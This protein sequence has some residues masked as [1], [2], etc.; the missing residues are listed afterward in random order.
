MIEYLLQL[1]FTGALLVSL[2]GIALS[3]PFLW[4][5]AGGSRWRLLLLFGLWLLVLPW[6]VLWLVVGLSPGILGLG[7]VYDGLDFVLR[8][9]GPGTLGLPLLAAIIW[10][11]MGRPAARSTR[12]GSDDPIGE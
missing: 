11:A 7:Y 8:L 4:W 5:A 3:T 6:A 9:W 12:T 1:R 2:P 10:M